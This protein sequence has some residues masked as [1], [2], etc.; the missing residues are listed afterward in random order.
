[1]KPRPEEIHPE[2]ANPED[3][4]THRRDD[5]RLP[6]APILRPPRL[7]GPEAPDKIPTVRS[8]KG[9]AY[10]EQATQHR[11]ELSLSPLLPLF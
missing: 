8:G 7:I 11:G 1:M 9:I 6:A 2:I 3:K 10:G 4:E 5:G